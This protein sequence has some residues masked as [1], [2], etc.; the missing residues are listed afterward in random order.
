MEVMDPVTL[1]M[2]ILF[3]GMMGLVIPSMEIR[4]MTTRA[5]AGQN[6]ATQLTEMMEL[7]TPNMEILHMVAMAQVI[8]NTGTPFIQILK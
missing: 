1:N 3:T 6:I 5:R 4:Y 2:V 7:V 8:L